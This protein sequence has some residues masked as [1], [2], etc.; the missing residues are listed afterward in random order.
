MADRGVKTVHVSRRIA[1]AQGPVSSGRP[2]ANTTIVCGDLATAVIDTM[3]S[4]AMAIPVLVTAD[5]LGGGRG[6]RYVINT[7]GDPD[8]LLGNG[9]FAGATVV[10]H[11][12]VADLLDTPE[13]RERYQQMLSRQTEGETRPEVLSALRIVEPNVTFEREATVRLGGVDIRLEYVGPAHSVADSIAWIEEE[14]LLVTAD[15][16]FNGIFPLVRDDLDNWFAGLERAVGLQPA[17]VVPGHG[18]IGGPEL[19]ERQIE[20]LA[21]V[22]ESVKELYAGGVSVEAAAAQPVP[23]G[24]R[25]L[26]LAE[27]RWPGAVRGIYGVLARNSVAS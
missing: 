22:R 8:H 19:L 5:E 4:P 23:A 26:P 1:V 3:I 16:V 13:V 21:A 6:V 7:H 11:A 17:V 24:L 9:L 10:A 12:R 14:R 2:L 27:E 20:V 15:I 18:E 25:S